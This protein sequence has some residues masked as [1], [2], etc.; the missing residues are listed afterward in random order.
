MEVQAHKLHVGQ[1]LSFANHGFHISHGDAELILCK[2]GG[3]VGVRMCTDVWIQTECHASDL[4]LGC[5]QF[6]DDLQL[7]N[8]LHIEAEDIIVKS[9]I[10]FPIRLA[11]TGIH[12]L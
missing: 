3:D 11:D 7:R 10:D 2:S 9:Q 8:A 4:V 1:F 5:S 6:I 12:D